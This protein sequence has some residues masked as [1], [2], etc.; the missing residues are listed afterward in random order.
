MKSTSINKK[1][2]NQILLQPEKVIEEFDLVYTN[3]SHLNIQRLKE[4]KT[5]I[6]KYK[7]KNLTD[8][9]QLKR[10]EG[11]VIPPAWQQVKISS[12]SNTHLQA[13][14]RDA[15]QRK[16]Y[17]YHQK[18]KEIRNQTKYYKMVLF[19]NHLPNIR[20]KVD[21]DLDQKQ[22]TKSKVLALV[23]KLMEETHIRIGNS[24][25]AKKNKTYGLT[26]LRSRHVNTYK[27][28][29]Q[30]E[31]VGKKGKEHKVSIRNKKLIRLVNKCE[32]IPGWELFQYYDQEGNKQKIDSTL[33]NQ[34]LKDISGTIFTAKDFRTWAAS[35]IFFEALLELGT[36]NDKNQNK[37]NI[38]KAIDVAAKEL[39]NTRNVCKKYYIHPA[40]ISSYEDGSIEQFFNKAKKQSLET[41][42]FTSSE[43][44][45]KELLKS[46]TTQLL[47]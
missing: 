20:K 19:A 40:I 7:G 47:S 9:T 10:I 42:Y 27:D 38:L 25:Y 22:W 35:I 12:L 44:A 26:T 18:W 13:V 16:Q 45:L 21:Q 11:L 14:G 24:Q 1:L 36:E 31:F 6:F 29:I 37:K 41:E 34:Y 2:Y 28:K 8:Q 15:K 39:G 30:F 17:K 46:Y 43:K 23:V 33:L 5:F 32:E 4:N 3:P